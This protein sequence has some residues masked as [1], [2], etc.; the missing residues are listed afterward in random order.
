MGNLSR[1]AGGRAAGSRTQNPD[2]EQGEAEGSYSSIYPITK[3]PIYSILYPLNVPSFDVLHF[4]SILCSLNVTVPHIILPRICIGTRWA[5]SEYHTQILPLFFSKVPGASGCTRIAL[6]VPAGTLT[7][8]F[9]STWRSTV[10]VLL[11][12][13][14]GKE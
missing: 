12:S 8:S 4:F 2:A 1:F 9:A 13:F 14:S 6:N 10:S 7:C 11:P 5:S 3:L